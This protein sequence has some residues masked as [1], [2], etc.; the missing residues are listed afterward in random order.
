VA[1]G[2]DTVKLTPTLV[3][4]VLAGVVAGVCMPIL[5]ARFGNDTIGMVL[6]FL[7]V[8]AL[9]AHA[10]VVGFNRAAQADPRTLDVALLKRVAA[11]LGAALVSMAIAQAIRA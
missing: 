2:K 3:T 7:L 5:W 10:L 11:W 6:S 8:V 4:A 9:P 1:A